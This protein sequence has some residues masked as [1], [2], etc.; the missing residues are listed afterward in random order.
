M[1]LSDACLGDT[2]ETNPGLEAQ[3]K[4]QGISEI[5]TF[6]IQSEC[7]VLE[8][9]KAALVLGF[10]VTILQGAHSTYDSPPKSAVEI[11]RD[12][13]EQLGQKGA[14]VI[15]WEDA[16]ATWEQRRMISSYPIFLEL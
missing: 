1:F 5:V 16:I 14:K 15:P 3:L 12:V 11:E 9:S 2:F 13:E 4:G 8:T 6:G 10:T 7:C